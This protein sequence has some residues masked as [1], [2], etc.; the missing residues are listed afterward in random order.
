LS[1]LDPNREG[2]SSPSR[3]APTAESFSP[4]ERDL[5]SGVAEVTTINSSV[6][7]YQDW[8]VQLGELS[9]DDLEKW[10]GRL[11]QQKKQRRA[12]ADSLAKRAVEIEKLMDQPA[13]EKRQ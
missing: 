13:G 2:V 10:R 3:S 4:S 5:Q 6:P 8:P 11:E 12:Q 7:V 9:F 1:L